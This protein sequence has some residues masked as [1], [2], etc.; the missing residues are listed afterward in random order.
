MNDKLNQGIKLFA[1]LNVPGV[2]LDA[3]LQ[4][5]F[6]TV[7]FL[8]HQVVPGA[9][10]DQV[11]VVGRRRNGNGASATDISVAQLVRQTLQLVGIEMIVVP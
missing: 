11:G 5:S 8:L 2:A 6:S 9:E 1:I 4:R 3:I 10:G 7:V